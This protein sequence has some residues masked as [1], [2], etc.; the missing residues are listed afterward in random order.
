MMEEKRTNKKSS[1]SFMRWCRLIH[2][3]LSYFFAGVVIIYALS[4][5]LMNHR[6]EI[7][8][9]YSAERIEIK[10]AIAHAPRT[11]E[12]ITKE[13]VMNLLG[14]IGEKDNYTKL[15]YP[16]EGVMRVFLRGGSSLEVNLNTGIGIYDKLRRRPLLSDFVKLHYNPGRWGTYFSDIFAIA[17]ITITLTGV[18]LV[19]GKRG[20]KGIG[21][22]ELILGILFPLLFLLL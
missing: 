17:L 13:E 5:I 6:S 14:E 12:S 16:E 3:H 8:P 22:V 20:L 4:G 11:Q 10:E 9:H 18:F 15:Y 19:K 1:Q 2:R 7:N 21:G